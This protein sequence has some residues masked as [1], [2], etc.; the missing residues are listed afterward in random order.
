VSESTTAPETSGEALGGSA[1][2]P[3]AA[4]ERLQW[5]RWLQAGALVVGLA[6]LV[7]FP[8]FASGYWIRVLSGVF[9]FAALA[10]SLNVIVGFTGLADFGN[11]V[12]LGVGA[13]VTA[14]LT[15]KVGW[16]LAPAAL[17]G[18]VVSALYAAIV[19]LPILRLKGH[20]FAIAT[21]GLLEFTREMVVNMRFTGG[22]MGLSLPLLRMP[23]A[24][25]NRMMYFIMLS[26][27]VV[28]ALA[29]WWILNSRIGYA[30]RAIKA[31]PQI[32]A[33]TGVDVTRYRVFAWSTSAFLTGLIGGAYAFWL[34]YIE[35]P[36][37]F[38][39]LVSVKYWIMMLLGGAG[40]ILGPI[41]GAFVLE[42]ISE[43]V[44]GRY[45]EWHLGVLGALMMLTV[46]FVPNGLAELVSGRFSLGAI[47]DNVRRNKI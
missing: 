36:Q 25:F 40:T 10:L 45:L 27:M 13:Y 20:Y 7:V 9:M 32:A 30:L 34:N 46:I 29:T 22:G 47:L 16:H 11:V 23:P 14:L 19:G 15:A 1:G 3:S 8:S 26:F 35:P 43:T 12:Y 33:A 24:Q 41:A 18:A 4:E 31:D 5:R 17:A 21:I 28:Y 2:A 44:W 37:V 39:V 38:N 6:I 42:I